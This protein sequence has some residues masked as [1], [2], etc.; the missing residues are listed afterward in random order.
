MSGRFGR[1][2]ASGRSSGTFGGR[3]GKRLR[4][5]KGEPWVWLT[6]EL[7][8]SAAW[9]SLSINA[10]RFIDALLLDHMA[11]AGRENGNLKATYGQL[12]KLGLTRNCIHK[13]IAEAEAAGLVD[14]YRGGMRV[15]T[16]FTLT[17]YPLPD[18]TPPTNR[19]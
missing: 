10:R 18:G 16:T 1:P 7:I 14:C 11:H 4:P 15:A 12:E 13:A 8:E 9:R 3:Q 2:D 5:P 17:F 19:W 6:R